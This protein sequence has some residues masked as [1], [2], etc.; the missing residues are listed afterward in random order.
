[1]ENQIQEILQRL[2][3][4]EAFKAITEDRHA[5]EDANIDLMVKATNEAADAAMQAPKRR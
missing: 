5:K 4:L 3:E 2:A 1:M